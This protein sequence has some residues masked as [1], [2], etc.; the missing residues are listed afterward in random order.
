MT[1]ATYSAAALTDESFIYDAIGTNH[2]G[3]G[4]LPPQGIEYV[5]DDN[6]DLCMR[7]DAGNPSNSMSFQYQHDSF[8]RLVS[9]VDIENGST[10][11]SIQYQYDTLGRLVSRTD[12]TAWVRYPYA[13]VSNISNRRRR[14]QVIAHEIGHTLYLQHNHERVRNAENELSSRIDGLERTSTDFWDGSSLI[15][16]VS[17]NWTAR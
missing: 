2:N 13:F 14:H 7:I 8:G 1:S 10:N 16:A 3:D 17:E 4:T 5:Y 11:K 6:G 15:E 9:Q 12:G